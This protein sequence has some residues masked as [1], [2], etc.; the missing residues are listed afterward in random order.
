MDSFWTD[1][2]GGDRN[3]FPWKYLIFCRTI[4]QAEKLDVMLEKRKEPLDSVVEFAID[5]S[6][7]VRRICGR[8]FHLARSSNH[9]VSLHFVKEH[10]LQWPII[11]R[12]V[13]PPKSSRCGRYH[14]RASSQVTSKA[15]ILHILME[16]IFQ[17]KWWQRGSV[18]EAIGAVPQSHL[19]P[20]WLLQK[21]GASPQVHSQD[22][23]LKAF[24]LWGSK[25]KKERC[26]GTSNFFL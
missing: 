20:C 7:L 5:D 19:A 22:T 16:T 18:G 4:G 12:R 21:E 25:R 1:S 13:P 11:P 15:S 6:L 3:N 14:W 24:C 17:T 2:L 10:F 8:W 26:W 9:F 23:L